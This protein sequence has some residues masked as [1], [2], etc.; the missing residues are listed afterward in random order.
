MKKPRTERLYFFWDKACSSFYFFNFFIIIFFIL[1]LQWRDFVEK[2][3]FAEE[4]AK[5]VERER[6]W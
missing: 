1:F 2:R 6:W 5:E 3:L 4:R